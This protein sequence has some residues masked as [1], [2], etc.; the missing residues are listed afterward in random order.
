MSAQCRHN[1]GPMS[2]RYRSIFLKLYQ[3]LS[4][5][6]TKIKIVLQGVDHYCFEHKKVQDW[7]FSTLNLEPTIFINYT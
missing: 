3:V 4:N 7:L 6:Q 2:G 5:K 1:V